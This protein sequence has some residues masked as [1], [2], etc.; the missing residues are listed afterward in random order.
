MIPALWSI[1][2]RIL[3]YVAKFVPSAIRKHTFIPEITV[4]V[5]IDG[6]HFPNRTDIKSIV[7]SLTSASGKTEIEEGCVRFY[8]PDKPTQQE[9]QHTGK[10]Q[11]FEGKSKEFRLP[12]VPIPFHDSVM[13]GETRLKAECNLVLKRP[14]GKTH[15]QDNRYSYDSKKR[16]FCED[17]IFT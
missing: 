9:E 11:L 7:F 2:G 15:K 1:G 8:N 17:H 5:E 4:Y 6:P 10:I 13:F 12:F 14:N 3:E 16:I